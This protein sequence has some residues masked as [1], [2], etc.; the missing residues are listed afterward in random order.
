[1]KVINSVVNI[2]TAFKKDFYLNGCKDDASCLFITDN[3]C[4][5]GGYDRKVYEVNITVFYLYLC[6]ADSSNDGNKMIEKERLSNAFN[7][8]QKTKGKKKKPGSESPNKKPDKEK[9][10]EKTK[11]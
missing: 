7:S 5:F 4:Y 10:T 1:M 6:Q 9:K 3:Y 11:K 8:P 2:Q